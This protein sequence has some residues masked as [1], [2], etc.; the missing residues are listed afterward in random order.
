MSSGSC[1]LS[2]RASVAVS[3]R[4]VSWTLATCP[5]ACTPASVRP[6]PW[7]V[8]GAPSRRASTCSS[9]PCTDSPSACRCQPTNRVPS[10]ARVSLSVRIME[11]R[12]ELHPECKL[13][14]E[15]HAD[16]EDREAHRVLRGLRGSV[17][18]IVNSRARALDCSRPRLGDRQP[19]SA[20]W[21]GLG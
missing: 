10:Y 11:S 1:A 8:T 16:L 12:L 14:Y 13:T 18:A 19:G 7:A 2:A 5:S 3:C 15:G 9:V 4:H 20:Q 6:A 21:T 17:E